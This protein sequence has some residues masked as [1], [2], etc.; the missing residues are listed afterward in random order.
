[1]G[2]VYRARHQNEYIAQRRGDVAI[3]LIHPH[4]IQDTSLRSRFEQEAGLGMSIG[5]P[6][7]ARVIDFVEEGPHVAFIM[8]YVEGVF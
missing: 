2:A 6:N 5:H 7:I 8:D 1:M 3:K 4:L